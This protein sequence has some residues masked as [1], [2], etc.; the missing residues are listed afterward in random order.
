MTD[1]SADMTD[2]SR[3]LSGD[4]NAFGA[5]V[6]RYQD[7]VL[8]IVKRHVPP[9]QVEETAQDTFVR[10]YQSLAGFRQAGS[11]R[12]WLSAIAVR[13]CYDFWRRHYRRRE[14]AV[15]QLTDAHRHWLEQVQAG[16]A[17]NDWQ[18]MGNR[19]EARG[20][21][22]WALAQL[23]AE[24]RMVIELVHL[25][26]RSVQEAARLLGWSRANVKVRAFRARKKLHQIIMEG[27]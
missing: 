22:D 11:F 16:S 15:S 3:V 13:T 8:R 20:V 21:L 10:A 24:D 6:G 14:V 25:E 17:E 19:A 27:R 12:Q 7:H 26:E 23:S 5:L 18:Q 9:D 4:A 1:A 2:V